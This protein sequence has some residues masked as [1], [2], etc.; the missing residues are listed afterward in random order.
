[1][2]A[3]ECTTEVQL[4]SFI[5]TKEKK[6]NGMHLSI[7]EL[8]RAMQISQE[9]GITKSLFCSI[10]SLL[11]IAFPNKSPHMLIAENGRNILVSILAQIV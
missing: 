10:D 3:S 7:Y 6:M 2:C 9:I 11:I 8:H 1:M 4:D 5:N